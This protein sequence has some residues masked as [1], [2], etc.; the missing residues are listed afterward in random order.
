[1]H[2]G[3]LCS[4]TRFPILLERAYG[5]KETP[6]EEEKEKEEHTQTPDESTG[7]SR[8]KVK[9]TCY[10]IIERRQ[11]GHRRFFHFSVES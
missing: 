6:K 1:V 11:P 8:D 4:W 2:A 7:N 9:L 10:R 5:E 3:F